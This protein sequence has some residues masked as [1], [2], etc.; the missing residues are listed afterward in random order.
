MKSFHTSYQTSDYRKTFK[1]HGKCRYISCYLYCKHDVTKNNAWLVSQESVWSTCDKARRLFMLKRMLWFSRFF[2]VC[3]FWLSSVRCQ[4]S[5][6]ERTIFVAPILHYNMV[7][8]T[9]FVTESS[10]SFY[11][12][13][14]RVS[15]FNNLMSQASVTRSQFGM[16]ME[17]F[18][19]KSWQRMTNFRQ[20]LRITKAVVNQFVNFDP[21]KIRELMIF[22][23]ISRLI[24]HVKQKPF[25][26]KCQ[27]L[28]AN[29]SYNWQRHF[30][31]VTY[32]THGNPVTMNWKLISFYLHAFKT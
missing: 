6:W 4:F 18:A 7:I 24:L 8:P 1:C 17:W 28:W 23:G 26:L 20:L 10:S 9:G 22:F 25:I 31:S 5:L 13:V 11:S 32:F 30:I 27:R 12:K 29:S 19:I 16:F 15:K 3:F 14:E 2:L 21:R